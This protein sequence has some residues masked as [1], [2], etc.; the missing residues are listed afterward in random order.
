MK[1]STGIIQN[2]III[3]LRKLKW[4]QLSNSEYILEEKAI[5]KSKR[6][7]PSYGHYSSSHSCPTRCLLMDERTTE[8]SALE[9]K[10][11][12]LAAK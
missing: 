9:N 5:I 10:I 1:I 3:P 11:L 8:H 7:L 4:I 2:N 6:Y 12:P